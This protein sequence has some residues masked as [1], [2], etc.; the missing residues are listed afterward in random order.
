M[1]RYVIEREVAGAGNLSEEQLQ[2]VRKTSNAALSDTGP[3]IQWVQSFVTA[4]RIY[5]H[6]LA[7]SEEL[8]REHAR[9]AGLPATTVSEVRSVDDPLT[10]T[11]QN[12]ER[13]EVAA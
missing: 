2:S 1:N 12:G 5:C 6:Y 4:D 3:G 10:A 7:E 8:V 11:V 9:R 13:H